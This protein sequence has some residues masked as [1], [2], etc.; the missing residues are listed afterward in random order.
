MF[1]GQ[2]INIAPKDR[3]PNWPS[4]PNPP[5]PKVDNKPQ[6]P[7]TYCQKCFSRKEHLA[8]HMTKHTGTL[9]IF[10]HS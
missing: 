4:T 10:F 7:C 9:I 8:S 2:K 6:F 1:K 5:V 3:L